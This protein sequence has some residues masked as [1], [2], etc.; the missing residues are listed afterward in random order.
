MKSR[1]I[2]TPEEVDE[3]LGA[4]SE[5]GDVAKAWLEMLERQR[6]DISLVM[7]YVI[8]RD[9][10]RFDET[11]RYLSERGWSKFR[12][13]ALEFKSQRAAK[14]EANRFLY[15]AVLAVPGRLRKKGI[16]P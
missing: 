6:R 7:V 14:R 10:W 4:G 3:F 16:S 9:K 1:S 12:D 2:T 5:I 13:E 8:V 15:T 11:R